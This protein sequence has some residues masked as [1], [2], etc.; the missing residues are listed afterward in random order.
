MIGKQDWKKVTAS[1]CL[2]YRRLQDLHQSVRNLSEDELL[3]ILVSGPPPG[4]KLRWAPLIKILDPLVQH[5]PSP[6]AKTLF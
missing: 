5:H 2:F 4:S 3:Q 1:R 6:Q